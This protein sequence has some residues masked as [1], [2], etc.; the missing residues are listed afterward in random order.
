MKCSSCGLERKVK[1]VL[2]DYCG[3]NHKFC[4]LCTGKVARSQKKADAAERKGEK[5]KVLKLTSLKCRVDS[6]K[7]STKGAEAILA[8]A[9]ESNKRAVKTPKRGTC[10]GTPKLPAVIDQ[11]QF[12]PSVPADIQNNP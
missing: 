8:K 3:S 12:G 2:C 6:G 10:A 7:L 11:T 5:A 9:K 1:D 4:T